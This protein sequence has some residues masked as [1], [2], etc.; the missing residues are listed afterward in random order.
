MQMRSIK[1]T[2]AL[3]LSVTMMSACKTTYLKK[4]YKEAKKDRGMAEVKRKA[5]TVRVVYPELSMFDFGKDEIKPDAQSSLKRFAELLGRYDRI[6]FVING[7][8]DNVG[9]NDVNQSLS[10]SRAENAKKLFE[11]NGVNGNRM[12][13]NGRGADNPIEPNTTEEGRQA[14]RRVEMLLYERK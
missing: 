1:I 2:I 7:Y 11:S 6:D 13:T 9:A 8:T 14:N 3:V 10:Q 5:D 4:F 12:Q